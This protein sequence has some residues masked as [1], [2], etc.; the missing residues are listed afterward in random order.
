MTPLGSLGNQVQKELIT[1]FR[2]R[3]RQREDLRDCCFNFLFSNIYHYAFRAIVLQW[4]CIG[5]HYSEKCSK[6][7]TVVLY[8]NVVYRCKP[9][10][11]LGSKYKD[12]QQFGQ[13]CGNFGQ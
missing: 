5:P 2:Q 11:R 3:C 7:Q 1:T 13:E 12:F 9:T 8:G 10:F 6:L 4:Y